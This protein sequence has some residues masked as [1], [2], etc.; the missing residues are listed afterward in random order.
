MATATVKKNTEKDIAKATLRMY[1]QSPRKVRLVADA[2]RGKKVE[3]ALTLLR[4]ADKRAALPVQPRHR[5]RARRV[6]DGQGPA[7]HV[8][9]V[10]PGT[11]L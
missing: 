8:G 9:G 3:E 11:L 1:R 10:R 4:F 7:R 6:A 2:I 5:L